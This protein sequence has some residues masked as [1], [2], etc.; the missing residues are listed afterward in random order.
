MIEQHQT[1]LDAVKA[2]NPKQAAQTM[3]SHL[4]QTEEDLR[5]MLQD[6]T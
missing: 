5:A 2:R 6:N 4:E 3:R 1:I